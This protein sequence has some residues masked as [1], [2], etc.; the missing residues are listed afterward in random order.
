MPRISDPTGTRRLRGALWLLLLLPL[1]AD[2]LQSSHQ[3]G[4]A[5]LNHL[6]EQEQKAGWRLL[7]DGGSTAGWRGF[8]RDEFPSDCWDLS[9]GALHRKTSSTVDEKRCG[10]LLTVQQFSDFHL[11]LEWRIAPKGN[12]GVKYRVREDRPGTW[13]QAYHDYEVLQ[14]K[15]HGRPS[16]EELARLAPAD[17]R[18]F[19]MGFEFQMIDDFGNPDARS[20]PL[21]VTG[22]LY[23]LVAPGAAVTWKLD[24][25]N[26]A[27]IVARGPQ[28][29]HWLNGVGVL[30]LRTDGP[31]LRAAIANSKFARMEGFGSICQGHIALQDHGSQV[32]FRNIK[33]REIKSR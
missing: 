26:L 22:A 1:A 13:E 4:E 29:E 27:E 11:K 9:D 6:S 33:I 24:D 18:Y 31:V 5:P 21:R 20:S 17:W 8:R 14:A 28:V 12:S 23:D 19:P 32:W 16:H 10:D 15:K 30:K 3:A 2:S 25:F 7:F